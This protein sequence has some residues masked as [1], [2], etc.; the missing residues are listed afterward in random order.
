[1]SIVGRIVRDDIYDFDREYEHI[2]DHSHYQSYLNFLE[3]STFHPLQE[4]ILK[5][6]IQSPLRWGG[7]FGPTPSSLMQSIR[8][9]AS[10]QH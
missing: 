2:T 6:Q 10:Q 3:E 9:R 7:R 1:M 5:E 4:N 8:E